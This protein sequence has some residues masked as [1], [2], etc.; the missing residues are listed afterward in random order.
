MSLISLV[1]TWCLLFENVGFTPTYINFIFHPIYASLIMFKTS[2][3]IYPNKLLTVLLCLCE[4]IKS[5]YSAG[6]VSERDLL[7]TEGDPAAAGY[8]I[9]EALV[10]I[11]SVVSL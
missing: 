11:R 4:G 7:R 6:N 1:G 5:G 8:T 10:L 3:T 9:K 2:D